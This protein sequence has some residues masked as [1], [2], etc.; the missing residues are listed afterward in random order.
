MPPYRLRCQLLGHTADVRALATTSK[1]QIITASRDTTARLWTVNQSGLYEQERV[2]S[3]H[4]GYVTSVC[5]GRPSDPSSE[6]LVFTGS[7]DTTIRV[8]P[9]GNSEPIRTLTGHTDT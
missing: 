8:Y 1:G 7:R 6:D 3:G 5:V 9:L 2:Y 4:S